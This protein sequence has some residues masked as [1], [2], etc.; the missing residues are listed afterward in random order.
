MYEVIKYSIW[1]VSSNEGVFQREGGLLGWCILSQYHVFLFLLVYTNKLCLACACLVCWVD[2]TTCPYVPYLCP[3]L[4]CFP[5]PKMCF[6]QITSQ[7]EIVSKSSR[8]CKN[9]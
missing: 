2:Y 3:L 7:D 6:K 5:P 9:S 1:V 8:F 4:L